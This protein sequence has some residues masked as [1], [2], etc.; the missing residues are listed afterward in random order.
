MS[1]A[2]LDEIHEALIPDLT[3][4]MVEYCRP[5]P[6]SADTAYW[7]K[8]DL[9]DL[10]NIP[11]VPIQYHPD[12][13]A[14]GPR[15]TIHHQARVLHLSYQGPRKLPHSVC[16]MGCVEDCRFWIDGDPLQPCHDVLGEWNTKLS[17]LRRCYACR[18]LI[19]YSHDCWMCW[20]EDEMDNM[21]EQEREWGGLRRFHKR[22]MKQ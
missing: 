9:D 17:R 12:E 4:L 15:C 13:W 22:L 2:L 5:V 1:D 18:Q 19:R 7:I 11:Q 6:I 20:A 14:Y 3:S 8:S 21:T 10:G 16:P